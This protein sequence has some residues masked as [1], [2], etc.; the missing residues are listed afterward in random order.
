[1]HTNTFN[2][3]YKESQL[4]HSPRSRQPNSLHWDAGD[5]NKLEK[6][7]RMPHFKPFFSS[8]TSHRWVSSSSPCMP[9]L[10]WWWIWRRC[11]GR[12]GSPWSGCLWRWHPNLLN[13]SHWGGSQRSRTRG[14][15][16]ESGPVHPPPSSLRET[17]KERVFVKKRPPYPTTTTKTLT[18][19]TVKC[20]RKIINN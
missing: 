9:P 18:L 8:S 10:R 5:P 3:S 20:S 6:E 11:P 4:H 1:M 13:L 14:C 2:L 17:T 16:L 19:C 15:H 7:E 12:R